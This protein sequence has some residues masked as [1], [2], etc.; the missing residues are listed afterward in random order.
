VHQNDFTVD[1][2]ADPTY[3]CPAGIEKLYFY[4]TR[5]TVAY[6]QQNLITK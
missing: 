6:T 5:Q 4:F 3:A 1:G 2:S